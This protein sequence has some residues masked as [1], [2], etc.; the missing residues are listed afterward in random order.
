MLS[1]LLFLAA[2]AAPSPVAPTVTAV[3]PTV[4]PPT[5]TATPVPVTPSPTPLPTLTPVPTPVPGGLYVDP[6]M[7]LGPISHFSYGTNHGPWAVVPYDSRQAFLDSGITFIRFPGGNWGDENDLDATQIDQF[8]ALCRSINAEPQ[9]SVRLK[10]GDPGKAA[11]LVKYTLDKGYHVRYWSIGNE[12]N[13]YDTKNKTWPDDR[14][15]TEWR[16]IAL[17][18]RAQDPTIKLL[19]PEIHQFFPNPPAGSNEAAARETLRQFL[20][21]N[22]DLVDIV[23]IHRYPFPQQQGEGP[24]PVDKLLANPKEWDTI[25]PDLRAVIR[26]SAGRDLPIAVTEFNSTWSNWCCAQTTPD[27]LYGALWLGDVMGRMIRQKVDIMTMFTL[28]HS[29]SGLGLFDRF[30]PK[31]MYY[32]FQLYKRFGDEL[33][34]S[35]SDDNQVSIY[36]ARRSDGTL[37]LMLLNL[38]GKDV[39]KPL[40]LKGID[41]PRDAEVYRL[42]TGHNAGKVAAEKVGGNASITLPAYSMSLY[43]MSGQ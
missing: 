11:A 29:Q 26:E 18:M 25:I 12:P 22:G 30:D 41:T 16:A 38:G 5:A 2:C 3:P 40:L 13:L 20:K 17:A 28:Q 8:I 36:T 35:S 37:T 27:S 6:S 43:V 31:P 10:G 23:S 7:S 4:I 34:Y 21:V 33:I 14:Y 19:G 9:I 32:V 39:A 15:N 42:D 1:S 24:P